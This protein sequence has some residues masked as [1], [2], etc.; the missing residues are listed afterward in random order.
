MDAW[1]TID[2]LIVQRRIIVAMQ[3]I[4]EAEGCGL[5]RAI[6]LFA[7]RLEFL[8]RTRPSDFTV[9]PEEYGRGFYT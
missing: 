2:D 3:A 9:S 7:E 5:Q 8:K 1:Q 4:R 6:D